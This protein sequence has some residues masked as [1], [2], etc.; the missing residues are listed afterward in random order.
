MSYANQIQ[1]PEIKREKNLSEMT[2]DI[3]HA[4]SQYAK[5]SREYFAKNPIKGVAIAAAAGAVIGSIITLSMQR[6]HRH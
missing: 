6:K 1:E 3:A 2:S 4:T 5:D